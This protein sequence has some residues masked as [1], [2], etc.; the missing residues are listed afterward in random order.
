MAALAKWYAGLKGALVT[1]GSLNAYVLSTGSSHATLAAIGLVVFR[2]NHTNTGAATLAV[3]GLT[4]K[5]LR[6]RGTTLAAN[7]LLQDDLYAFVYNPTDDAFDMVGSPA[8]FNALISSSFVNAGLTYPSADG[9][10]GQA[11]VTN[12]SG[13]L[14]FAS[15]ADAVIRSARTSNTIL[16]TGDRGYL[17]D[18]TSGTFSQTFTAA[19]TL[20]SGWYVYI[21][22]S[23]T[24]TI[25]LDPNGS[26]TIDGSVTMTLA[27]SDQVGIQCDGSNFYTFER[28]AAASG[29]SLVYLTTVS[30]SAS[31]TVDVETGF[32]S[33][34][35]DYLI[36]GTGITCSADDTILSRWKIGGAYDTGANYMYK[37]ES[38]AAS[39]GQTS[40]PGGAGNVSKAIGLRYFMY[41]VTSGA[42][43]A[44]FSEGGGVTAANS[45]LHQGGYT[46]S[47]TGTGAITGVRFYCFGGAT[48]TGT[49]RLYGYKKA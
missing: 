41:S 22:N 18:I 37:S 19:A 9:T 29:N 27:P 31:A 47:N 42:M 10:S 32:G 4:A 24:G 3:D 14:S 2:A 17:I 8:T 7:A 16:G 25:T 12:A 49:F 40:A 39:T 48:I 35:D 28:V 38:S 46:I 30:P 44:G 23:G 5:N 11:I 20:G 13:T 33:T 45:P 15:I 26:E 43:K 6:H 34:Y 21:R 1:T 36:I